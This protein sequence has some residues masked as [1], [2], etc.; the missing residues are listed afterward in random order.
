[1]IPSIRTF[2]IINLLLSVALITSFAVITNL[3]LEHQQVK[4][5]LDQQLALRALTVEAL[6]SG[7]RKESKLQFIQGK[8]DQIPQLATTLFR[9]VHGFPLHVNMQFQVWS[10]EGKVILHSYGAPPEGEITSP[11]G[12]SDRWINGQ[13]WRL[14][15]YND[16][17]TGITIATAEKYSFREILETQIT[18]DSIFIMLIT[19][20]FLGF[21]IWIIVGR[22]LDS[23]KK[24]A[25]EVRSRAPSY[26]EPVNTDNV[27]SE[28][29]P[30]IDEL[31]ELFQR[32]KDAFAREKRFA[33]DA[34]HE[35]RTPLAALKTQAQV[36]QKATAEEER[37][38]ALRKVV[39]GVDRSTHVVQQL[40]ILSRMVPEAAQGELVPVN[41]AKHAAEAVADL[42][43]EALQK[44]TEIE[45]IAPTTANILGI[46]TAI[47]ILIRNL[48]D[49]AIRY[50]PAGSLVR[51]SIIEESDN[52]ILKVM[53]NGPGIPEELRHRVF[54][55]FFR[56]LGTKPTGSGLG[57]GIVQ[58]IA[59]LLN[60]TVVLGQ[61]E[62]GTG[63]EVIVT[64]P[65]LKEQ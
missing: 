54:E 11:L 40:L 33:A 29:R 22:G 8:I 48:L 31:N 38:T 55:R 45:L 13:L 49:N 10:K 34:A 53:D 47:N 58:Q 43:P 57:L 35:L 20:P 1:M 25:S 42:V 14:Y 37:Q 36:A 65:K 30:M 44:N 50:T 3:F 59:E 9:D 6:V 7:Y 12:F 24:I 41:L 21:M 17:E 62:V 61:P 15:I 2:L 39:A 19:Y 4:Y 18:R 52:V 32:L 46:P 16:P 26:L 60:A 63:L 27:P 28:I 56:L 51:V 5:H 64:F 23:L